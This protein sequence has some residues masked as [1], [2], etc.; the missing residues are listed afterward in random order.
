MENKEVKARYD[1]IRALAIKDTA[2]HF[3]IT[4]SYVRMIM[5]GDREEDDIKRFYRNHYNRLEQAS[6]VAHT[7]RR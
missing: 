5:R 3:G 2:A 7:Q 4:E 6:K 1:P